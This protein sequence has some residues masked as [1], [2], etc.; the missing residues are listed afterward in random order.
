MLYC[1]M[2]TYKS[3][4]SVQIFGEWALI[5]GYSATIVRSNHKKASLNKC[6]YESEVIYFS[7]KFLI[8]VSMVN[9]LDYNRKQ[10]ENCV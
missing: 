9:Y 7:N 4:N 5:P 8:N 6:V 2:N 10:K 3:A 1:F